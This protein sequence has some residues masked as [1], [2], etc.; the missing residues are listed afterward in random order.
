MEGSS[1]H[2]SIDEA[3]VQQPCRRSERERRP[4]VRYG[5]DKFIPSTSKVVDTACLASEIIEP[6]NLTEAM[7]G[8]Y[9][10]QWKLAAGTEYESLTENKTWDLV[11]LPENEK[12]IGSKWVFKVKHGSD[13]TVE[14]F[15]GRLVAKGYAQRLVSIMMRLFLQLSGTPLF[16]HFWLMLFKTT[17]LYT[18]WMLRLPS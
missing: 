7:T 1:T 16:V 12:P 6:E 11:E 9:A 15:K 8:D 14:R 5:I 18:K 4:P 17:Y 3:A 10:E 2:Q 13:G